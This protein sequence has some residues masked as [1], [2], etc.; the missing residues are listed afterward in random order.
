ML[1]CSAEFNPFFF[2]SSYYQGV[3]SPHTDA[4]SIWPMSLIVQA[5]TSSDLTEIK[6]LMQQLT[7]SECV[8]SLCVFLIAPRSDLDCG[9]FIHSR[10]LFC[11]RSDQLFA[12]LVCLGQCSV[13]PARD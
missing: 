7:V 10:E 5:L 13:W 9:N 2:Q 8:F 12:S 11:G 6:G 3:G 1:L 4:G